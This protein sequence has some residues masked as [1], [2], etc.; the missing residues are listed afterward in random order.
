MTVLAATANLVWA[1]EIKSMTWMIIA[2]LQQNLT[3][4]REVM[5][6]Q[7]E[8]STAQIKGIQI[9][10]AELPLLHHRYHQH[11]VLTPLWRANSKI[12]F[13]TLLMNRL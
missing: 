12:L 2:V 4:V 6:Q 10:L 7:Q 11:Q 9:V 13:L 3:Q 5:G 8:V 1:W